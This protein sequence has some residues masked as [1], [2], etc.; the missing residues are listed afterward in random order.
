MPSSYKVIYLTGPPAVGKTTLVKRLQKAYADLDI[1]V[2]S[3]F[4]TQ[5]LE[6]TK[7]TNISQRKLRK[8]SA[9][10]VMPE[11]IE[12]VDQFLIDETNRLRAT[13]H[14]IID[15]HPVTKEDYGFRITAF[16]IP[17]LLALKPTVI[18]MLYAD[19]EEIINRISR[20][21]KGRP[22]ATLYETS[23][24]CSMQANV[25]IIYG[26]QLGI[27]I[28]FFNASTAVDIDCA[29]NKIVSWF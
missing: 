17:F 8:N 26:I 21:S 13:R 15:S 2:Y 9:H 3:E 16:S 14:I 4:L 20:H 23:L 29:F 18:C 24:H 28:Y 5:H 27:P 10:I 6:R 12:K 19:A 7:K 11:D 25:A 22:T 1:F